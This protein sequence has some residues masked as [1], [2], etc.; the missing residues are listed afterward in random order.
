MAAFQYARGKDRDS[1]SWLAARPGEPSLLPQAIRW[2]AT[3]EDTEG[4]SQAS[5]FVYPC[6]NTCKQANTPE[7][8]ICTCAHT[9]KMQTLKNNYSHFLRKH[10]L[11]SASTRH[12]LGT[13][14]DRT[15]T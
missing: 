4:Y 6:A 12:V 14:T 3:K 5:T 7:L 8:H 13:H 15:H 11:A 1:W 2:R 10:I 9:H